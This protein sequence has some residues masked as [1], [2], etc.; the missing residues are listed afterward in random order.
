MML[1]EPRGRGDREEEGQG[2]EEGREEGQG[3]RG[4]EKGHGRPQSTSTHQGSP[5]KP[6]MMHQRPKGLRQQ[7]WRL[8]GLKRGL[9]KAVKC[10]KSHRGLSKAGA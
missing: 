9:E 5:Q 10:L 3:S 2:G 7:M 1:P 4:R 6:K 8:L